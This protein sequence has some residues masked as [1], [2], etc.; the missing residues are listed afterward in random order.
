MSVLGECMLMMTVLLCF[1]ANSLREQITMNA[2]KESNP[3][4]GSS[5]NSTDG[6]VMSSQP[7][8]T[9]LRSPPEMPFRK[10]PPM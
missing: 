6:S 3:E 1:L 10:Y 4:V 8:L 5:K 2:V 7:I 9:R